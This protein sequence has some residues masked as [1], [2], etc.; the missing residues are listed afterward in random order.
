ME[1]LFN[2]D[3]EVAAI[4]NEYG[5]TIG[6]LTREDILDTVFNF[7]PSRS[8]LL[9]NKKPIHDIADGEWIVAGV[10]SLR[11]LQ[12]YLGIPL[13]ASKSITVGG[14]VQEF[15]PSLLLTGL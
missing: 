8:M 13:P 6:I 3:S 2:S 9:M 10:T 12:R 4:V 5:D 11:R 15:E 7:S 14:V 1:E